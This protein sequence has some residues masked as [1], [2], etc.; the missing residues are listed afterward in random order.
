[1]YFKIVIVLLPLLMFT[2]CSSSSNNIELSKKCYEKGI[3][4]KCRANFI[5]YE[6]NQEKS[7]CQKFI[8][9]G[10]GGNVPF[11][12]LDKCKKTCEE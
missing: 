3:K 7:K 11:H 12:T 6:Y 9:G 8:Y 2:A 10:C 1:M 4:G 5:K